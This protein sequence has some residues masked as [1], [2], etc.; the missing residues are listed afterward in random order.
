MDHRNDTHDADM[1]RS[2]KFLRL[3]VRGSFFVMY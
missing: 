2:D 3:I 1:G